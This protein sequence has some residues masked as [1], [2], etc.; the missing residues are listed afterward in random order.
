MNAQQEQNLNRLRRAI[1]VTLDRK[2]KT[3]KDFDF[4]S[5]SL[6]K[7][8]H[9]KISA[10][11]LK[12]I[13]GY[14]AE[15]VSPR[16]TTLNL[17]AQFVGAESWEDFCRQEG[18]EHAL[19]MSE[20]PEETEQTASAPPETTQMSRP[21]DDLSQSHS[22]PRSNLRPLPCTVLPMRLQTRNSYL[23][24]H[25]LSL[26]KGHRPSEE[27]HGNAYENN[28]SRLSEIPDRDRG[29]APRS[30]PILLAFP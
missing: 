18:A 17:L 3:P 26:L 16:P 21:K 10:T 12:R 30:T 14:L 24:A 13:W 6:F 9:Q 11:T 2:M 27:L 20:D 29:A 5:D 19:P 28:V 15:P 7:K 4:L 23:S 22:H 25:R 1:E 8:H